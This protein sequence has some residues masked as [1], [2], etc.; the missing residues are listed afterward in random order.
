MPLDKRTQLISEF[1]TTS[2][3][4]VDGIGDFKLKLPIGQKI[5]A[6]TFEGFSRRP[7]EWKAKAAAQSPTHAQSSGPGVERLLIGWGEKSSS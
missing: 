2:L 4:A 1:K 6:T 5:R 7:A 3:E